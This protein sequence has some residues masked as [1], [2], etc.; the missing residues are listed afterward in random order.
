M[1]ARTAE[2]E[3]FLLDCLTG[4]IECGTAGSFF[5]NDYRWENLSPSEAF[6]V[7][8]YEDEPD[9]E[10]RI[11]IETIAKGIGVIAT[12]ELREI[13]EGYDKGSRVLHNAETGERLYLGESRKR[14]ILLTSRTNADEGDLD[15]IDYLAIM[16]CALF[17]RVVYC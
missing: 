16:E 10:H 13:T 4:A 15:V 5:V 14:E 2:R 9:K 1:K 11:T 8:E 6:A 12:S 7:I 17:G 3:E